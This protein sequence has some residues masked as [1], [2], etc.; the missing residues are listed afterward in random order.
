[1]VAV[2]LKESN[3]Q[4]ETDMFAL[5]KKKKKTKQ[6]DKITNFKYLDFSY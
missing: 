3:G 5:I 6:E 1:M 4:G 2:V